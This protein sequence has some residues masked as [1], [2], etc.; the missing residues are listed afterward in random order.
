MRIY[1]FRQQPQTAGLPTVVCDRSAAFAQRR[2]NGRTLQTQLRAVHHRSQAGAHL[3]KGGGKALG[4]G[5]QLGL[6]GVE[7]IKKLE[8]PHQRFAS[9]EAHGQ[10]TE[11][12]VAEV[13]LGV[14]FAAA[15]GVGGRLKIEPSDGVWLSKIGQRDFQQQRFDGPQ[16]VLVVFAK[17]HSHFARGG[18][19]VPLVKVDQKGFRKQVG[20]QTCHGRLRGGLRGSGNVRVFA[21]PQL[22]GT[23]AGDLA[24]APGHAFTDATAMDDVAD[25]RMADTQA[26]AYVGGGGSSH[27]NGSLD[28]FRV[29]GVGL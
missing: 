11:T 26:A 28:L 1:S 21:R 7:G 20:M 25:A 12:V 3:V 19:D 16:N 5:V 29:H 10:Q 8:L 4:A 13:V 14:G 17:V 22:G 18:E 24:N 15:V 27:T 9:R 23:Q 2:C 6:H